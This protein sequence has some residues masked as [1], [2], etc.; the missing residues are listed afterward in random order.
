[1]NYDRVIVELLG[2]VA[3]LEDE[4]AKL[5][6][7]RVTE[8]PVFQAESAT[9][10][11]TTRYL[12]KGHLYGKGRLVLAVVQE[13]AK[14]HPGI[15][16]DELVLTFDRRLQGSLGVVRKLEEV[17]SSY[18]DYQ[19][20]FFTSPGEVV[21]TTSGDCVVCSQWGAGN[22]NNFVHRATNLGFA[23]DASA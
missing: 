17:K 7:D 12:F 2:R 21:H 18:P 1:M 19:R 8:L 10:R 14:E 11:D 6:E 4:V 23:I 9:R 22:I 16:A 13:Y 5:K 3:T 20:R 15:S